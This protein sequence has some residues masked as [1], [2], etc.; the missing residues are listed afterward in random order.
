MKKREEKKKQKG[1]FKNTG[2]VLWAN[3]LVQQIDEI[4]DERKRKLLKNKGDTVGH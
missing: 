1:S 4:R 3:N 2:N